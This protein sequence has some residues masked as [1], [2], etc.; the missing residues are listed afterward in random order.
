MIVTNT[1]VIAIEGQLVHTCRCTCSTCTSSTTMY[2]YY[3]ITERHIPN[4]VF[5]KTITIRI[6][7]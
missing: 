6:G 7:K 1:A 3:N 5:G 4:N 2:V